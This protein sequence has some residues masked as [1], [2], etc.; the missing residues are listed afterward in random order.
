MINDIKNK[1]LSQVGYRLS[2]LMYSIT[3]RDMQDRINK[4]TNSKL[5]MTEYYREIKEGIGLGSVGRFSDGFW[6]ESH[7]NLDVII[8]NEIYMNHI[9]SP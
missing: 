6:I 3:T 8:M 9:E 5:D 4:V 1:V 7:F 2:D